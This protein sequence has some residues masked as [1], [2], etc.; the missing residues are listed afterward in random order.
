MAGTNA[1]EATVEVADE[2]I[3]TVDVSDNPEL[4]D[5]GKDKT[6]ETTD[7][8]TV[9]KVADEVKPE[10]KVIPRVKLPEKP[11]VD[12]A[13]VALD[14]A[15]KT[16]ADERKARE[17]AEA[18]AQ[19]E[20]RRAE[21]ATSQTTAREQEL[22]QLREAAA[23][24]ELTI[25]TNGIETATALLASLQEENTRLMEAGEFAKVTAVQTKMARAAS[26]LDRLEAAKADF[27]AGARKVPVT[28]GRVEAQPQTQLSPVEQYLTGF[29]PKAQTW[30]RAHP[31]CM[32]AVLGGKAASNA[33]MMAGHWAAL[34]EGLQEGSE[35]YYRVIEEHAGYRT[36][37]S[38]AAE[39]KEAGDEDEAEEVP[40]PRA[41]KAQPSAPVSR[42]PPASD[43]R[44]PRTTRSVTLNK[45]QQEAAKIS[46]PHL[47]AQKA[48]AAYAR[49]LLELE[50]EGKMGRLSH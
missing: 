8:A 30:L 38:K 29:A 33:K 1:S 42:E 20:R 16:A 28:E 44:I 50:A 48:F 14:A 41:K 34:G 17:A 45:E 40:A 46:F 3:V 24:R 32:P 37:V 7:E 26:Q 23:D 18:T 19:A 36:P 39:T 47:D 4:A 15:V 27:E 13:K 43:G 9:V 22:A 31:D 21:Q 11:A 25:I 6:T 35:D 2:G 5:V 12:E 10:K 49:N